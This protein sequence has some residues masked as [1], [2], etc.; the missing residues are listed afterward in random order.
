MILEETGEEETLGDDGQ[1][2]GYGV[3]VRGQHRQLLA[4][5]R[6][7]ELATR[8]PDNDTTIVVVGGGQCMLSGGEIFTPQLEGNWRTNVNI[9]MM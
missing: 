2:L 3:R 7:K 1:K 9:L 8:D 5:K 6:V 4:S